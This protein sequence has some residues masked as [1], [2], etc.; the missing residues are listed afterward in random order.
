MTSAVKPV[1]ASRSKYSSNCGVGISS[2]AT[3]AAPV[4]GRHGR[5]PSR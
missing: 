4:W 5:S 2:I 1:L 3:V